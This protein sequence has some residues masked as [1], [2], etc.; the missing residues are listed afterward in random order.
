MFSCY[1]YS[2]SIIIIAIGLLFV[3]CNSK[4]DQVIDS[5]NDLYAHAISGEA[6]K[7]DNLLTKQSKSFLDELTSIEKPTLENILDL[8][9]KYQVQD[10]LFTYYFKY[11]KEIDTN[12]TTESFYNF[13]ALEGAPLFDVAELYQV[14]KEK[15]RVNPVIYIAIYKTVFGNNYLHWIRLIEDDSGIKYDL[16]YT[17]ELFNKQV[18]ELNDFAFK[19][20]TG[21]SK[22]EFYQE[23]VNMTSY[24]GIDHKFLNHSRGRILGMLSEI[25]K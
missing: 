6:N 7:V 5:F 19:D 1:P 23:I 15:T 10:L 12:N 24:H 16:L 17:L 13:L 9:E 22:F 8:G 3:S 14:N 4:K 20:W 21:G 2:K 11:R 25:T 18:K